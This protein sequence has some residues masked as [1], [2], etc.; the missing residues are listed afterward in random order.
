MEH[1]KIIVLGGCHTIGYPFGT[2]QAFPT[3]L[4]ELLDSEVVVQSSAIQFIRLA[5]QLDKLDSQQP[6]HVIFQ[7]G[8]F[9]FSP[10][11]RHV[12][13][14]VERA[15]SWSSAPKKKTSGADSSSSSNSSVYSSLPEDSPNE[16]SSAKTLSYYPRVVGLGLVFIA[17]WLFSVRH[18]RSFS[19]LNR[20]M[21]RHPAVK[22]IFLSPF[23]HLDPAANTLRDLGGWLL[24]KQLSRLS[25]CYW[26]DSHRLVRAEKRLFV[27]AGHLNP[28]AHRTLA[29]TLAAAVLSSSSAPS[30]QGQ[31][32][33]SSYSSP[34]QR[35]LSFPQW[36][37]PAYPSATLCCT[38]PMGT[39][40]SSRVSLPGNS[41]RNVS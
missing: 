9:E 16:V 1:V 26:F 23:P 36:N 32:T 21:R 39:S 7:L 38:S 8:N 27:D 12:F 22:F 4:G 30:L 17:L 19:N 24:R 37:S 15:L 33:T 41:K 28:Q 14:Q 25:N 18:R 10:S 11:V 2:A 6:S 34:L 13:K 5:Q 29:Y 3:V 35:Q 31:Y 20:Y 40:A